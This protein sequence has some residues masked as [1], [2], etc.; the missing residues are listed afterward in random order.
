MSP[1]EELAKQILTAYANGQV[2]LSKVPELQ[3]IVKEAAAQQMAYT[4]ST[5]DFHAKQQEALEHEKA[6]Y[7]REINRILQ[8][9]LAEMDPK[10]LKGAVTDQL[11]QQLADLKHQQAEFEATVERAKS[12]GERQLWQSMAPNLAGFAVCLLLVAVIFFVLEKLI[13][14]GIWNGWG[15]HKLYDVV[16]AIQPQHPYGAI[17]LG[18]IGFILIAV[19]I[20][21]SFWLLVQA[22]QLLV[23]FEPSKLLFWKKRKNTRW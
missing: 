4:Y 19:T 10:T 15:L 21:A 16:I 6:W 13:Y 14:Q 12:T 11:E 20:Y 3:K 22:V 2:D 18:I 1:N 5:T 9:K 23:D 17:V 8:E 7:H